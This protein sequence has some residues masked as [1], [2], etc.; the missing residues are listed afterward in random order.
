SVGTYKA[1]I[2]VTNTE[3]QESTTAVR[4]LTAKRALVNLHATKSRYGYNT[5]SRV[6]HGNCQV[7]RAGWD[8]DRP[9]SLYLDCRGGDVTANYGFSLPA[10]ARSVTWHVSGSHGFGWSG[11]IY[12]WMTRGH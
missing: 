11:H 6:R 3:T 5:S 8:F 9:N 4:T 1:T 7:T 12:K 2:T 10:N